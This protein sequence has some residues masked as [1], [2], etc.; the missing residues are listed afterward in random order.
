MSDAARASSR[1]GEGF[2]FDAAIAEVPYAAGRHH[3][4]DEVAADC[5]AWQ[6]RS[7][8]MPVSEKSCLRHAQTPI[9]SAADAFRMD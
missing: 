2:R 4:P 8:D 9:D 5:P 6:R 3:F 7:G 1:S